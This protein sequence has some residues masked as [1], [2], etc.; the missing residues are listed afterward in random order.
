MGEKEASSHTNF[1]VNEQRRM[2]STPRTYCFLPQPPPQ[3]EYKLTGAPTKKKMNRLGT[4]SVLGVLI[5]GVDVPNEAFLCV[6][7]KQP[8][9]SPRAGLSPM[10]DLMVSG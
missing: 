9:T 1:L 10:V 5:R 2:Q 7:P 3:C 8:S 6:F 4:L